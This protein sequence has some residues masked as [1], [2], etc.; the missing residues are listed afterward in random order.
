MMQTHDKIELHRVAIIGLIMLQENLAQIQDE[1]G[2]A[3]FT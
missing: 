1:A 3:F 2:E